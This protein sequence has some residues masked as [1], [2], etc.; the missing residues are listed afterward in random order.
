MLY[1]HPDECIDCGACEPECPVTAIFPEEDVPGNL[2]QYIETHREVFKGDDP[3][4]RPRSNGQLSVRLGLGRAALELSWQHQHSA[5]RTGT[6]IQPSPSLQTPAIAPTTQLAAQHSASV[7]RSPRS[8]WLDYWDTIYEA[9]ST[10]DRVGASRVVAGN[11]RHRRRSTADE[12]I[13]L[14]RASAAKANRCG[15]TTPGLHHR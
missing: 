8:R 10:P 14:Y 12:F 9:S 4:G 5:F 13:R 6:R 15:A 11:A 7:S 3:P 2:K 1:I